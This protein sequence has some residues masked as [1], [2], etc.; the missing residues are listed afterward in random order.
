MNA[1]DFEYAIKKDVR[2]NPIVREVDRERQREF[3]RT[4][5]VGTIALAAVLLLAYQ[6]F[7]LGTSR[8]E[9]A[10]MRVEIQEEEALG[11]RLALE[12]AALEN[13]RRL[14]QAAADRLRMINPRPQD[15]IVLEREL[16]TS[17]P[18]TVVASRLR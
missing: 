12:Q 7:W 10:R 9:I 15:V 13:P 6:Q 4:L 2:N 5:L 1:I 11:R 8:A 17:S 18:A 16:A 3:G 14:E